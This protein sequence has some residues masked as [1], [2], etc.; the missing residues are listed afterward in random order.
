MLILQ[1]P[2]STYLRHSCSDVKR[3]ISKKGILL[4]FHV[5]NEFPTSVHPKN[6]LSFFHCKKKKKLSQIFWIELAFRR[7][8]NRCYQRALVFRIRFTTPSTA[9]AH[10]S[11][12]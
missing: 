6:S 1:I 4:T 10:I 5:R 11:T 3:E 7:V 12:Y 2:Y 8:L 9:S